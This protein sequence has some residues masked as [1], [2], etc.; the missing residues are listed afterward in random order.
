VLEQPLHPYTRALLNS[1]PD[2]TSDI[3]PDPIP[4]PPVNGKVQGGCP[5]ALRCAQALPVCTT[6]M[7]AVTD[8]GG[9]RL[10][11]CHMTVE[12][13]EMAYAAY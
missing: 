4:A 5:F 3:A 13:K 7:P 9:G 2:L 11:A 10:Y 1:M 12:T 6:L 8:A